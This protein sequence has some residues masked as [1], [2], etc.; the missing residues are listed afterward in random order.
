MTYS[1]IYL[2]SGNEFPYDRP[3]REDEPV[4]PL[5]DWAHAAA[6]GVLSNLTD[7]RGIKWSLQEIDEEVRIEIVDSL[8]DIIRLAKETY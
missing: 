2:K 8:A 6:R 7:R 5:T 3:D 1:D 4:R